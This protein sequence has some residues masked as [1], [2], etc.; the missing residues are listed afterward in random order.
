MEGPELRVHDLGGRVPELRNLGRLERPK[1]HALI[2]T[3]ALITGV[4]NREVLASAVWRKLYEIFLFAFVRGS[5]R[6]PPTCC[7]RA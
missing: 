7:K 5:S 2:D 4:T 1:Y 6:W 3:G